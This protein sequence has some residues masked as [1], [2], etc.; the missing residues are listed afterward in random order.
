M[1]KV[2]PKGIP[3][4]LFSK[5]PVKVTLANE[6]EIQTFGSEDPSQKDLTT[7]TR[8]PV[9][10]YEGEE[11]K[12]KKP[13]IAKSTIKG[14]F[15][16][17]A[18]T[19]EVS[20]E[21]KP[22]RTKSKTAKDLLK[23]AKQV[24]RLSSSSSSSTSNVIEEER[25]EE[26]PISLTPADV[27]L[28]AFP[29]DLQNHAIEILGIENNIPYKD[30][31]S[32]PLFPLQT[33]LG[34][35]KAIRNIYSSF[36]HVPDPGDKPDFDACSKLGSGPQTT[37]E[38]YEYQKFVRDYMRQASPYRG[39]LVYHGLGSGKT[40]S[41]I[42]A[43]EALYSVSRKK[44]IVM[45]PFSLR[46]NFIR[47]VSFCGFRH[48]R[49]QN[50]WIEYPFRTNP[51]AK[52]F[53][54]TILQLSD[55]Y[56]RK[57]SSIWLP[58]FD[59]APNFDTLGNL[60]RQAIRKQVI[61]Q[62][63]TRITFINYNGITAKKLKEMICAPKDAEGNGPFDNATIVIDEI[64]NLIRLMEGTIE[65]YLTSI[66]GR[67][68]KVPLE[69]ITAEPWEPELC[70]R[71]TDPTRLHLTTYKRGYVLY[72]LLA[73]ARN[74]K[75]I[76]L[77]GTPLI[78]FPEELG[79]LANVLGGYMYTC[80]FSIKPTPKNTKSPDKNQKAIRTLIDQNPFIDF[81]E[82]NLQGTNF[83]V[84]FSLLPEGMKKVKTD[85]GEFAVQQ[86]GKRLPKIQDIANEII[87]ELQTIDMVLVKDKLPTFNAEP[88]LP[89]LSEDF[90]RHF[91]N[92][93]GTKLKNDIVI[94][95]RLQGL[96]SYYKGSKKELMPEVTKD[97]VIRIPFTPYAQ[98]EY[99]RVRGEEILSQ[100]TKGP[101]GDPGL[102]GLSTKVSS[103]WA[104]IYGMSK[105]KESNSYRMFSRQAC[106]FTFPENI[107]RPRPMVQSDIQNE[108]GVDREI[109]DM[110]D[111]LNEGENDD[112]GDTEEFDTDEAEEEDKAIDEAARKA[113]AE[114]AATQ[115]NQEEANLILKEGEVSLIKTLE[116]IPGQSTDLLPV[117]Q[118]K[119][120]IQPVKKKVLTGA[121]LIAKAKAVKA[122]KERR[123]KELCKMGQI[124]G[125]P[126]LV[127]TRRSKECLYNYAMEK[128]RLYP[129]G[130]NTSTTFSS[131]TEPNPDG[132]MKYSPKY[133]TI[134]QKIL[135][136][137]GSSLVYSQF[138]DMEG[139]GIFL[140]ALR[141]NEFEP[142][143]IVLEGNGPAFS[144]K[145]LASLKKGAAVNRYLSFTGSED[146]EIRSM[147]LKVFN[148]RYNQESNSFTELPPQM[149]SVLVEAGFT[150]NLHGEL[151]RV[152]C[153]TS[154][155]AEGLSLRNVR[156]VHIMEPYW[157]HVR[158]DQVKGRAV[159][160]CS[161]MDL[162]YSEDPTL[163][164]RN[165]EVYT[166]CSVFSPEALLN[167]GTYPPVDQTILLYD[168]VSAKQAKQEGLPIPN[169]A[170]DYVLTSDEHLLN[171]SMKKKILLEN[172]QSVMKAAAVDCSIN[173]YENQEDGIA[174]I[175]FP[176]N[177]EQYAYHP[178]LEKDIA[179]TITAFR[180]GD[181]QQVEEE[182]SSSSSSSSTSSLVT[183]T[184]TALPKKMVK[185]EIKGIKLRYKGK[186]YIAVPVIEHGNLPLE[187]KLYSVGDVY[188]VKILGTSIADASGRPTANITLLTQ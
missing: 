92:Q 97:E 61:E 82:V 46:D 133:A 38:M 123:E 167:T 85:T 118:P 7:L 36:I 63:N 165:V 49:L 77:S 131:G 22:I 102:G 37:L 182:A 143:E 41:A 117:A 125:E 42:A 171:I 134:L 86:T 116:P 45:T 2:P 83:G 28:S 148:A 57:V 158:T 144:A 175:D 160:I 153:I 173:R 20:I 66:P 59:Q 15:G 126:Y 74:A 78:N 81:I 172:I 13:P 91:L 51:T 124:S 72:R 184:T 75:I 128:M 162:E 35:G 141:C 5:G 177:A 100:K 129:V 76:G 70:K 31:T 55:D 68:R 142:I 154:A 157:N 84:Q 105:M 34:F 187:Y 149:S 163:N 170:K 26:K 137:P 96:I 14:M 108:I 135:E 6:E 56:L 89:P 185:T 90:H 112:L 106:N 50:H 99:M 120:E 67:K 140:I 159:R 155:G 23:Q 10:M 58:D 180:K 3:S 166:Y 178:V 27:D 11:E 53:A 94:A 110:F 115:G 16:K 24:T 121:E 188:G 138:L 21:E 30:P 161:H 101:S 146:R 17:K 54:Q 164:Q 19:S 183:T 62:I 168:G 71:A 111:K 186:E 29:D 47:E 109:I 25:N 43:A 87:S 98:A 132:L 64:H 103:V 130:Q 156:R 152:F 113:A 107:V 32:N 88:I 151:C 122:E 127:A 95:K 150:G 60:Q 73:T 52:L 1:A 145:T 18:I 181:I 114:D 174:C 48:F 69:P 33:R 136:A 44:I 169:G 93:D 179:E 39:L 80:T 9:T 79:I 119:E 65:P 40:C 4:L 12:I 104:E 147:A 139:I 176:G 8:K